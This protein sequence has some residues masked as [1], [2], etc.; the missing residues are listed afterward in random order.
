VLY[1]WRNSVSLVPPYESGRK[2]ED[3]ALGRNHLSGLVN[4]LRSNIKADNVLAICLEE[5]KKTFGNRPGRSG[6][7]LKEAEALL[8]AE[9][10]MPLKKR[11]PVEVYNEICILLQ[12]GNRNER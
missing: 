7:R 2:S 11:R 6:N 3:A 5:W 9:K 1:I 8:E 4:L 10:K 12:R